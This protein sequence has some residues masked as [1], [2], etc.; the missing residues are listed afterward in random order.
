MKKILLFVFIIGCCLSS[1]AQGPLKAKLYYA[2]GTIRTGYANLVGI[3]FDKYVFFRED[4]NAK[5][6]KIASALLKR[7]VYFN[8]DSAFVYD[9]L[10]VYAGIRQKRMTGPDWFKQVKS[11][12]AS[13][14]TRTVYVSSST[15]HHT[16]SA[17]FIDYLI[18]REGEPALK[19]IS[20]VA[21]VNSN[22]VFKSQAPKYFSDYP[23][24]AK[25][26]KTKVYKWKDLEEVVD[27]Y[28]DWVS[29]KNN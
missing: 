1:N 3:D 7:I 13:L 6:E 24:L 9:Y 21:A 15:P 11:G 29:K 25:K 12:Y 19:I 26:I 22:S 23:E 14:Y 2:D 17:A 8:E 4:F 5:N 18:I 27:I 28:N 10:K 20:T 16:T